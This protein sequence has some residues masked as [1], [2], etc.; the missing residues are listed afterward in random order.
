MITIV[1]S[2]TSSW[3]KQRASTQSFPVDFWWFRRSQNPVLLQVDK[4]ITG[5]LNFIPSSETEVA[6]L[7][8]GSYIFHFHWPL[9]PCSVAGE[10]PSLLFTLAMCLH[11]A[12]AKSKSR[13][14]EELH[15]TRVFEQSQKDSQTPYQ[16]AMR[17]DVRRQKLSR[18]LKQQSYN[19]ANY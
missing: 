4:R 10:H 5:I 7:L 19:M 13:R 11:R 17:Q 8:V 9:A 12:P 6:S 14:R 18:R 16:K 1:I 15:G 2:I 3:S